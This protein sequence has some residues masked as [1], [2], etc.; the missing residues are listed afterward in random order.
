MS[1]LF[2]RRVLIFAKEPWPGR[3][4][5]RLARSIGTVAAARWFQREA[6]GLAE[7]LGA[8]PRWE[9][10]VAVAPDAAG[11]K[12]RVWPDCVARWPQGRGDLG[13][14]MAR[15]LR[16]AP[17]GPA[18]IIGAD[19][20]GISRARI[21]EA[22]EALGRADAVIGPATDGGFWLVGLRRAPRVAPATLFTNCRWSSAHARADTEASLRGL[23]I[24]HV[25]TLSDVD[26]IEDLPPRD[27][28][29]W[30]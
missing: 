19:V 17:P 13:A 30:A 1:P 11:L 29:R 10:I 23:S 26:E 2:R 12:S 5:T 24:A 28:A 6:V 20:P 8:D 16:A 9:T 4:K 25:T 3:V 27:R 21:W 7:R 14:R 18:V 22:F 15:A